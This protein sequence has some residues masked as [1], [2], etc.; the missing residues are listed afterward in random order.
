[1]ISETAVSPKAVIDRLR[2]VR[3]DEIHRGVG[4]AERLIEVVGTL[5]EQNRATQSVRIH[6]ARCQC[7]DMRLNRAAVVGRWRKRIDHLDIGNRHG[8]VV[9]ATEREIEDAVTLARIG[10]VQFTTLD[11]Y[12]KS[13]LCHTLRAAQPDYSEKRQN[14]LLRIHFQTGKM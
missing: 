1:M 3:Y 6:C 13:G 10:I 7:V 4:D 5:G 9:I 12:G 2:D 8:R 14:Q 11:A